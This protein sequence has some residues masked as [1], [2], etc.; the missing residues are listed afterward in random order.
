M[1]SEFKLQTSD[2]KKFPVSCNRDCGGGC[3]LTAHV[4]TSANRLL[5]VTNS[6]FAPKHM[7]GCFVGLNAE[8]Q[9]YADGRLT[10]PLIRNGARGDGSFR[11]T[12]WEETLNLVAEKLS[13]T[14]RNYGADSIMLLSGS[15]SC[16]SIFHN[17]STIPKRFFRTF[18]PCIETLSSYSSA[19]SRFA[20]PYVFGTLDCGIDIETLFDS[21]LIILWGSNA[22][23]TRFSTKI[24]SVL[25]KIKK[26]GKTP[27][28]LID[29]RKTRSVKAIST[30][31]L[32]IY[33]GTDSAL[34]CAI[35]H[36][37]I[38]N[39]LVDYNFTNKYSVGF[40]KLSSYILGKTDG[41]SKN[42]KWAEKLCGIDSRTITEL[43]LLYGKTKPTAILPGLSIQRTLGGEDTYKLS[44]SLQTATGNIGK[45]GGSSG[46][47]FWGKLPVPYCPS[48]PIP[49]TESP[50][51]IP[52][53]RW[54]DAILK[55]QPF[56]KDFPEIKF[57]YNPGSNFLTQGA[58]V[59]KNIE[60]F[61]KLDFI[62]THEHFMTPTA[63]FSD[64]ILP[65]TMWMERDDV[66]PG[67]DNCLLYSTKA[68]NPPSSAKD[69]YD[70]FCLLAE[71][72]GFLNEFSKEKTSN[73]WI[74]S[75]LDKSEVKDIEEF[76][77][78]GIEIGKENPRVAF[79]NFIE[80]PANNP[81]KTP[82]GLIEISSD[83]YAGETG[84]SPFPK[85]I[86][87]KTNEMY[88]LRLVTPHYRKRINSTNSN[89]P[90][91]DGKKEDY[92]WINLNDAKSRGINNNE[93]V[94]VFNDLGSIQTKVIVTDDIMQ[95]VI[96]LNNGIWPKF[97]GSQITSNNSVN[98][99]TSTEPTLP[100]Q[101]SRTHTIFAEVKP[102]H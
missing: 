45:T 78:T 4:D 25:S 2:L 101:G 68:V 61:N 47:N 88:P 60:A 89:V 41:I 70:I 26:N 99:L 85:A 12:S 40:D 81:L 98:F 93:M 7:T 90:F 35:L 56:D 23:D 65:A 5:K 62:V 19:A 82:S 79:S 3:A 43:A 34:I 6:S 64:V 31:W 32:P 77:K 59:N 102:N 37:L 33:P 54:A 18:G 36:E 66:I 38:T 73:E 46:G 27:I 14:K 29:P 95:G 8:K 39:K 86:S 91:F 57:L 48:L 92:L 51:N 100:S 80:N 10:K 50:F 15:G 53:Y 74:K 13:S 63:R 1:T 67:V 75:L 30:Q 42:P 96:S 84:C 24:E 9:L 94:T 44:M 20:T 17:T 21:K 97:D 71:K 58:D 16:R 83:K 55:N 69:D 49:S 22:I 87:L 52:I 76:K 72:L 28:I 11:E